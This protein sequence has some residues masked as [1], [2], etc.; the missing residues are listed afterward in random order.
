MS[1]ECFL[2]E[3]RP[4]CGAR[5]DELHEYV[6]PEVRQSLTNG[7]IADYTIYRRG[8]LVITVLTRETKPAQVVEERTQRRLDAWTALLAPLFSRTQDERGAPLWAHSVFR[9]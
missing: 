3:L 5:Y 8:E 9:L 2:Y 4:G 6:W 1:T 7:G